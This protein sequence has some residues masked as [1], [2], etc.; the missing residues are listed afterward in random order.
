M[1]IMIMKIL[2]QEK[3]ML[4]ELSKRKYGKYENL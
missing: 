4:N 1:F 3:S 2:P